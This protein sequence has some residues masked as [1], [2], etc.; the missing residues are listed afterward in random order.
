MLRMLEK[1]IS[2]RIITSMSQGF[3]NTFLLYTACKLEIF[4]AIDKEGSNI[5][6]IS[7]KIEVG[8]NILYRIIRPLIVYGFIEKIDSKYILTESGKLLTEEGEGSLKGYVLY[9]GGICAKS[10]SVM[11]EAARCNESP[12]SLAI[13]GDLF[14]GNRNS[15]SD[16]SNF[17]AMMSF[18]SKSMDIQSFL[19]KQNDKDKIKEIVDIGGGTGAVIIQ[20]LKYYKNARG[21][22]LDLDFVKEKAIENMQINDV[23]DRADFI[24][25]SFFE[26][27]SVD[28]DIFI[29]SRVLHDWK[30]EESV[31]ILKNIKNT[32]NEESILYVIELIVP[33]E[34]KRENADIFMNDLQI[35]A[36]CGGE[37]RSLAQYDNLFKKAGLA[38]MESEKIETGEY[39]M[40]VRKDI[41][42]EEGEI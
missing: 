4:D 7:N 11:A 6:E 18:V 5:E 30:D 14:D 39:V 31:T 17:N 9:C 22:I 32:M 28:G 24:S 41:D 37:E 36:V 12:Y 27:F 26:P 42:I 38:L 2:K 13:G 8:K 20:F 34:F 35:W 23:L 19:K 3:S 1:E 21:K 29:L 10:W 33:E 15:I 16:Y 40:K 25:G